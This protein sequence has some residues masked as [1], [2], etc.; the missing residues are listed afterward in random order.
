MQHAKYVV[1][2]GWNFTHLT[3]ASIEIQRVLFV[4]Q[5]KTEW[6]IILRLG[7]L[8][9]IK[10]INIKAVMIQQTNLLCDDYPH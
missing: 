6:M 7:W 3:K 9:G 10:K 2:S 4:D 5:I 8:I 1:S